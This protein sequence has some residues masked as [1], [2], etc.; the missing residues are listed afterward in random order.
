[1]DELGSASGTKT[2]TISALPV[3]TNGLVEFSNL[4][5]GLATK[6]ISLTVKGIFDSDP[7]LSAEENRNGTLR[8][9]G[10]STIAL[11]SD[12]SSR[13]QIGSVITD[14]K[15]N[16]T[17]LIT[18]DS[19]K[20]YPLTINENKSTTTGKALVLGFTDSSTASSLSDPFLIF[21]DRSKIKLSQYSYTETGRFL[22]Q[23]AEDENRG[24]IRIGGAATP[25]GEVTKV[26]HQAA[27]GS[28]TLPESGN[29]AV[30]KTVYLDLH[31]MD[32]NLVGGS[33]GGLDTE[34]IYI[35]KSSSGNSTWKTY[36]TIPS[37]GIKVTI[38][39]PDGDGYHTWEGSATLI[40]LS[41]SSVYYVH[42]RDKM[43]NCSDIPLDTSAPQKKVRMHRF[44]MQVV[45]LQ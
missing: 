37:T 26:L 43:G 3:T 15:L 31:D 36:G 32:M 8:L 19:S 10:G 18:R 23:S 45:D 16:N 33:G 22:Y 14:T 6:A 42:I 29:Q 34:A 9:R 11:E 5:I 12:G 25:T 4:N 24:A 1:M 28:V 27:D 17:L 40:D 20:S 30:T 44:Q 13:L 41:P 21:T 39:N 38:S 35:D 2:I 7:F